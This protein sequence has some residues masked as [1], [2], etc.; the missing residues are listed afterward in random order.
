MHR[1]KESDR[2]MS[3]GD[4][5]Y[6]GGDSERVIGRWIDGRQ[7]RDKVVIIDKGAHHNVDHK[8]VIPFDITA[9]L[10]DSLARLKT[11]CIDIYLLHR[12]N[13]DVPVRSIVE[14]LVAHWL[15][16]KGRFSFGDGNGCIA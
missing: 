7:N 15:F 9:D 10:H 6:A 12:D 4:D 1:A 16:L 3:L 13:F 5:V 8:R 11:D 2:P 14:C